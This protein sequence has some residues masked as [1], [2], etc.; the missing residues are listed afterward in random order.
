MIAPASW[1]WNMS[2]GCS[3]EQV[4]YSHH[5]TQLVFWYANNL[6]IFA[7][8]LIRIWVVT[9][10]FGEAHV[11]SHGVVIGLAPEGSAVVGGIFTCHI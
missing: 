3:L 1:L 11:V 2:R 5:I 10:C 6:V 9:A 8:Y 4:L 7:Q